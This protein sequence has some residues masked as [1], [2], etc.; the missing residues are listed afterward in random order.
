MAGG[1]VE[2][3][4]ATGTWLEDLRHNA[5]SSLLPLTR[6]AHGILLG[7]LLELQSSQNI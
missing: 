7:T 5:G 2:A 6:A 3:K 1:K 4:M